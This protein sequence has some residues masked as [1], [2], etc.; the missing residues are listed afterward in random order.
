MYCVEIIPSLT[1]SGTYVS[2]GSFVIT[3]P[4]ACVDACLGIPSNDIAISNN[5]CTSGSVSYNSF[6][7]LFCS[8]AFGIVICISFGIILANLSASEYG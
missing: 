5:L 1:Y 3:T 2:T 6:N 7:S 4:Q 8:S